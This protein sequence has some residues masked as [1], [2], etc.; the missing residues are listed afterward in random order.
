VIHR[1][2]VNSL[3]IVHRVHNN[4]FTLLGVKWKI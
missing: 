3:D 4:D 2:D 1:D